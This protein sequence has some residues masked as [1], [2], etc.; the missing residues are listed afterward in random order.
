MWSSSNVPVS[1][2]QF[3]R[4]P[5][6]Y[7][8]GGQ[9]VADSGSEITSPGHRSLNRA[10]SSRINPEQLSADGRRDPSKQTRPPSEGHI[11]GP[12]PNINDERAS[13]EGFDEEDES[14]KGD[15]GA[16]ARYGRPIRHS[17]GAYAIAPVQ[18]DLEREPSAAS[19]A[20]AL[21]AYNLHGFVDRFR[22]LIDQATRE[23]EAALELARDDQPGY[24]TD[25]TL[26]SPSLNSED[27]SHADY[28]PIVGSLIQR[29]PTI[30]SLGSREVVSLAASS[31]QRGDRSVHSLSRPPTRANTL[32]FSEATG[33][34][35]PSRSNS[36]TAS[37][38]LTT[39]AEG[40]PPGSELACQMS[41]APPML[42]GNSRTTSPHY[43]TAG[44]SSS[45]G[46][47]ASN[48]HGSTV[49]WPPSHIQPH[50]SIN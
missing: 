18:H 35:P 10:S 41:K 47:T 28:V 43:A 9:S 12:S 6:Q 5:S 21:P 32:N 16:Y 37:V 25:D 48:A 8:V 40:Q 33:S 36:L 24:Y 3:G 11:A 34:Q 50:T 23:T 31:G 42:G 29:M 13:P 39:P 20:N 45:A 44:T 17:P 4:Q 1:L 27:A 19:A 14:T 38:I 15:S 7:T 49:V 30:E 2:A 46:S 22:E 26:S